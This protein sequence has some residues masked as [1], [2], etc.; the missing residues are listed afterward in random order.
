M[1]VLLDTLRQR[2]LKSL[3]LLY[4]FVGNVAAYCPKPESGDG[5]ILSY[6]A[7]LKNDFP[8]GSE[9]TLECGN[10]YEKQSG[11]GIINCIDKKWTDPDLVCKKKD[12]GPPKAQ[13]HMYFDTS[14]GTLFGSLIKVMCEEGYQ[15]SGMNYKKCYSPG[16]FGK[17]TCDIVTCKKPIEV[18]NGKN[19]WNADGKPEYGQMIN[20]TCSEG[21]VMLGSRSI[22][23]TKT[24]EYDPLPPQ[25]ID[26]STAKVF[27]ATPT[28][29][30]AITVTARVSTNISTKE[31]DYRLSENKTAPTSVLSSTATPL[32][33]QNIENININ[34]NKGNAAVI[35]SVIVVTLVVCIVAFIL[36]KFLMRRKGLVGTRPIF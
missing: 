3:L 24:G 20:F 34:K 35:I 15:I 22:L 18:E 16:W 14:G 4:L 8:E 23:C 9:V 29:H 25:C 30:R 12:C 10:G 5:I 6:E 36:N 2:E 13:P 32:K 27:T 11:S 31:Q 28:S 33:D 7:L 19:S 26:T 21:Y 1:D 17:S